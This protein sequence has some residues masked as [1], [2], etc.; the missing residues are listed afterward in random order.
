MLPHAYVGN[1]FFSMLLRLF[2]GLRVTDLGP[3]RAIRKDQLVG[4]NLQ[5]YTYG[6]T[7]EMMIKAARHD[8]RVMEIPVSYR[9]RL[10]R[11][12]VSGS[13]WVSLKVA[14]KMFLTM[15]YCWA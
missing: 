8:L 12:K 6:W 7:L 4:L 9:K 5:E 1:L 13:L 10:G 11:S 14:L 3:F 2:C 15:R